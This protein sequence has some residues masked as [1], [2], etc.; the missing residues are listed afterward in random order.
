MTQKELAKATGV[1]RIAVLKWEQGYAPRVWLLPKIAKALNCT[2]EE[3]LNGIYSDRK[4]SK[5]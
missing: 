1:S 5:C 4:R 2:V 3:V